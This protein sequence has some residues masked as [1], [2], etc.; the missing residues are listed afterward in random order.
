[1][2]LPQINKYIGML[3]IAGVLAILSVILIVEYLHKTTSEYQAELQN[4]M[5]QGMVMVVVPSMDLEPGAVASGINM[6]QRLFPQSLLNPNAVTESQWPRFEGRVLHRTVTAG[7]PLLSTDFTR[8]NVS[9][10]ASLLRPGMRAVTITVDEVNSIAG[11]LRSGDHIDVMLALSSSGSSSQEVLPLLHRA[12]VLAT[13]GDLGL[14]Q[15]LSPGADLSDT[16]RTVTLELTPTQSSEL[17]LASQLGSLR[18]ALT[19]TQPPQIGAP[20]MP[21]QTGKTLLA[22]LSGADF[23]GMRGVDPIQFII[24]SGDGVTRQVK[25]AAM[26]VVVKPKPK[27]KP[28]PQPLTQQQKQQRAIKDLKDLLQHPPASASAGSDDDLAVHQ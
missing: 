14:E 17:M 20:T 13:G 23:G 19:P 5:S 24:G 28:A 22:K 26:V 12:L 11:M 15:K 9:D 2:R 27:P 25:Y 7:K 21:M 6:S 3:V 16:F 18:V 8:E 1:M 10:F 4:K